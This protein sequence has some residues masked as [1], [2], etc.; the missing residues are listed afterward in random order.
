MPSLNYDHIPTGRYAI[1][2]GHEW[3]G[4]REKG[5]WKMNC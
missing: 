2:G 3:L 5:K 4:G 1:A